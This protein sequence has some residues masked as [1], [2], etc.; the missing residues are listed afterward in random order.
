MLVQEAAV[1]RLDAAE[2]ARIKDFEARHLLRHTWN[3]GLTQ[4]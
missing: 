2:L 3:L 1:S 4:Q